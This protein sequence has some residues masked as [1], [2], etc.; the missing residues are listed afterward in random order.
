MI[1]C[2]TDNKDLSPNNILYI[3]GNGFDLAHG[4]PT[5]YEDFHKW[6]QLKGENT[7]IN[8]FESLYTDIKD[9]Y[10]LWCDLERALGSVSLNNAIEFDRNYQDCSDVIK[11]ENSSHDAYI[12]GD[13][14]KNTVDLLPGLL[15]EWVESISLHNTNCSY[16]L[17]E[18][19]Y[20]FSFNYTKTLENVYKIENVF[21]VHEKTFGSRPLVVGYGNALFD[22]EDYTTEDESIDIRLIKNLLAHNRKPVDAI[23]EES[24]MKNLLTSYTGISEVFVIGCS[25]SQVDKPYFVAIANA[26]RTDASWHFLLHDKKKINE[27]RL[28]AD[29]VLDGNHVYDIL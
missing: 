2:V 11:G 3:I 13:N 22:E 25:C 26:I 14:L 7:F 12:C 6:L 19:A 18:D 27:I 1:T 16:H 15:K 9:N 23:L 5:K 28:F 4:L 20:F 24:E 10:G 29:S 8:R 21:H 17:I